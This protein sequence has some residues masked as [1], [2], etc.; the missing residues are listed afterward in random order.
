MR[1]PRQLK[2]LHNDKSLSSHEYRVSSG[3]KNHYTR[4]QESNVLRI[5]KTILPS[6]N[7][8]GYAAMS[9]QIFFSFSKN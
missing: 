6:S 7:I 1:L 8:S 9:K 2:L 5:D 4:K 3:N